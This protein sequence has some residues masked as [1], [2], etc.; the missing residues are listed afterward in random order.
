VEVRIGIINSPREIA[1]ESSDSAADVEQ[2][3][4]SALGSGQAHVSF[5]DDKDRRYIVPTASIAYVEIG[6]DKVRP[7]GFVA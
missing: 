3:V 5:T 6:S 7:V 4:A 2:V 1:F